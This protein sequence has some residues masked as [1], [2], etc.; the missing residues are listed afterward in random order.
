MF[1]ECVGKPILMELAGFQQFSAYQFELEH[2]LDKR[3][4]GV[5][6]EDWIPELD[7]NEWIVITGDRGKGGLK[8]GKKLPRVCQECGI[9]YIAL[10]ASAHD[11]KTDKKLVAIESVWDEIGRIA[12]EPPGQAYLLT[13]V[14]GR[15]RIGPKGKKPKKPK[16]P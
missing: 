13:I 15:A 7:P 5:K 2:I 4:Q 1:D 10:G 6:D 12:G 9:T 14:N 3:K 8:K 16:K 11:L